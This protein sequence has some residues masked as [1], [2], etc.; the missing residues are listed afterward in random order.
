MPPLKM[1]EA[2]VREYLKQGRVS[3]IGFGLLE[4]NNEI[5][6]SLRRCK[7]FADITLVGPPGAVKGLGFDYVEDDEPEVRLATM[8]TTQQIDGLVR[9]TLDDKKTIAAYTSLTN[10]R[11]TVC[12]ALLEIPSG[13]QFFLG[14]VSNSDGWTKEERLAET[15]ATAA[16][17]S[18]WDIVPRIAVYTAIRTDTYKSTRGGP[19]HI[20]AVLD[21]TYDDAE[22]IVTELRRSGYNARNMTID[23]DEAVKADYN[24]HVPINGMMGNQ[25][26]RA[27]VACGGRV[28]TATRIGLKRPYEDNSR[29]ERDFTPHVRWLAALINR[30][31]QLD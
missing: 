23:F 25:I 8:L 21:Q 16:F 2:K 12:P 9:G 22:W 13:R 20:Q 17:V 18:E 10:E 6:S 7:S 3:K 5:L 11:D 14:P 28:L 15:K 26:Y 30:R 1:F 19:A 31:R 24:L 27:L 4:R 29:A